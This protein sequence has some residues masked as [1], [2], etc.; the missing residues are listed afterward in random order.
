MPGAPRSAKASFCAN[1]HGMPSRAV[2]IAWPGNADPPLATRCG[3]GGDDVVFKPIDYQA[4]CAV[5]MRE[6]GS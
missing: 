4:F 3:M 2:R 5:F 1:S 6:Q